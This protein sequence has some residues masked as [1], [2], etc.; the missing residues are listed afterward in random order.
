MKQ[1]FWQ[2]IQ[3]FS[4]PKHLPHEK[5]RV[6]SSSASSSVRPRSISSNGLPSRTSGSR[7]L[8]VA[9]SL[10]SYQSSLILSERIGAPGSTAFGS[11]PR[12]KA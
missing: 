7:T 11:P 12:R 6:A 8:R 1:L 10:G 2:Y 5:Q 3:Q 4:Q 9:R